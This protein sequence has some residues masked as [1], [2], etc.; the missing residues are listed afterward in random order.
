ML[1]NPNTIPAGDTIIEDPAMEPFF[2]T[3][4]S[5]GGFTVL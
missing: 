1:R 2:I 5:S 4:S 3:N